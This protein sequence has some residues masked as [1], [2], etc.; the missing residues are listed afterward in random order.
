MA[1]FWKLIST[2]LSTGKYYS[3]MNEALRKLNDEYTMLHYPFFVNEND[4]FFTAQKNLTDYCLS[5]VSDFRGKRVLEI[6]CGNGVQSLYVKQ[7]HM[8]D[9]IKGIDLNASNIEIAKKE[10]SR[11]G[12]ADIEFETGDAQNLVNI[13]DNS[14]DIVINIESAFHYSDK[15][16]FLKE[17]DRIMKPGGTFILADILTRSVRN[18]WIWRFWKRKMN[19][20]HWEK[21]SYEN[22]FNLANLLVQ[23]ATEITEDVIK[24]F[25]MYKQWLKSMER[26]GFVSRMFLKLFYTI[27]TRLNIHLLNKRQL[28]YVFVGTS[29]E[30]RRFENLS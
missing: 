24:G 12:L 7:K 1:G 3:S 9:Y 8:P 17:I 26:Q 22:G 27:N 10:A 16:A 2:G 29:A 11:L 28:Y 6:G 30:Q 13:P 20:N 25:R 19:F 5:H 4:D 14:F 23:N 18:K 15:Q 21:E